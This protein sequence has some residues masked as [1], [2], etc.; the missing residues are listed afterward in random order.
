MKKP[1]FL[2]IFLII[3]I[4]TLAIVQVGASSKLSTTGI[5]LEN[6]QAQINTYKKE[7]TILEEKV[8]EAQSLTNVS[9]KA[10]ELGFVQSKSQIYLFAPLPLALKQ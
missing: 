1:L 2:I 10:K 4:V 8:L 6:L 9:K 5:E 3:T 7:N